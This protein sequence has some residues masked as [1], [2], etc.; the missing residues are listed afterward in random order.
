MH[1]RARR[2]RATLP[3]KEWH[4]ARGLK[5]CR[6]FLKGSRL[7]VTWLWK[8]MPGI[9]EMILSDG[10]EFELVRSRKSFADA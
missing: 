1:K 6:E 7:W 2:L 5:S 8:P 9:W 10:E 4:V 3:S